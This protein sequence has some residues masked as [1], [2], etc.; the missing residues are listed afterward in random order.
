MLWYKSWLETRWRFLIGLAALAL[1]ACGIV[2]YYPEVMK[3]MAAVPQ[4]DPSTSLGQRVRESAELSRSYRGYVWSQWFR[5][6]GRQTW[7]IF[8]V[9]LGS[10]GLPSQ[11][12]GGAALFTL[13]MPASRA[14]ILG[15][16]AAAVLGEIGVLAFVPSLLL[17][18]LSPA[19]G[20]SYGLSDS[21]VHGLCLFVAGAA[22]FSLAFLLSTI[23][24][25]VWRPLLIA[26]SAAG[27][28]S[29][30][31]QLAGGL[32]RFGIFSVMSGEL[33]FRSGE[34]PWLGLALSAVLSGAMLYGAMVNIT[35]QDF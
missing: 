15:V 30:T 12:S 16:R 3:L 23:F 31:E 20:Q 10:G 5:Q 29:L 33:Y 24:T 19:V 21:L 11:A 35:R 8:A 14:R 32:P 22:F 25:D 9:L 4:I 34:L 17:V 18:M 7:T 1:A 2:L 26:L 28:L 27:I 6:T 13:S